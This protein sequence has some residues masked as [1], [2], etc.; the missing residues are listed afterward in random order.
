MRILIV[1]GGTGGHI[2]PAISLANAIKEDSHL[3]E[4]LFVGSKSRMESDIVPQA[5][6]PFIGLD[7]TGIQGNS[8]EKLKSA[9]RLVKG[10]QSS[11]KIIKQFKPDLVIGFGNYISV[12]VILAASRMGIKTMIHEQNSVAGKA[13]RYLSKVV[14]AVV[15]CYEENKAEFDP[16]KTRILGNPRA[17]EASKVKENRAVLETVGLDPTIKTVIIVMGS[18]GSESVNKILKDMVPLLKG[19]S[20]QVMIVTGKKGYSLFIENLENIENVRIIPYLEGLTLMK[21]ADLLVVRGGATTAAEITAMQVP[22]LIIPSPY[23]PHDHQTKN[24]QALSLAESAEMVIEKELTSDVLIDKIEML[25]F[26]EEKL[27]EMKVSALLIGKQ[28][29]S[30]EIIQWIKE[31][32]Y[33]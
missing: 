28:N 11:K 17:S 19:K 33:E 25:L 7:I 3:N 29:A 12:P 13:N 18:L 21:Q 26:D 24:A 16:S 22:S 4:V 9:Y 31:L 2:Y 15:G 32:I 10:Y 30:Q 14:D 23:V 1:T 20:Y 5:G 8:I 27:K 6:Y